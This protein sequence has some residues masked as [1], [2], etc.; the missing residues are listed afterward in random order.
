MNRL[1]PLVTI[2]LILQTWKRFLEIPKEILTFFELMTFGID[3]DTQLLKVNS[4]ISSLFYRAENF[5]TCMPL[6][7]L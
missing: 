1:I 6:N 7:N 5:F 2:Y 3:N 4:Q